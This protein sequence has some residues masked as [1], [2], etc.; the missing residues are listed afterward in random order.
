M[1]IRCQ[2]GLGPESPWTFSPFVEVSDVAVGGAVSTALEVD[3]A[4]EGSSL[5]RLNNDS[6]RAPMR[7]C[8][9]PSSA[10][11]SACCRATAS[12]SLAGS[13][14]MLVARAIHFEVATRGR[15]ADGF[16][17]RRRRTFLEVRALATLESLPPYLGP[18]MA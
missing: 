2:S 18:S 1:V 4:G 16:T 9:S 6:N 10:M 8:F 11:A 12:L 13:A 7:L 17:T 14:G 5:L 3:D 15:C